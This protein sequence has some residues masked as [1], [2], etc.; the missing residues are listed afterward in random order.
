MQ[1][2]RKDAVP[3]KDAEPALPAGGSAGVGAPPG[4]PG[5]PRKKS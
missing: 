3:K 2:I 5:A 1:G 4:G